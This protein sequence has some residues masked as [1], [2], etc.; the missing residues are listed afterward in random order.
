MNNNA[1]KSLLFYLLGALFMVLAFINITLRPN[2]VL[3]IISF[4]ACGACFIAGAGASKQA[5]QDLKKQLQDQ[6]EAE[7]QE[8]DRIAREKRQEADRIARAEKRKAQEDQVAQL[9]AALPRAE[10]STDGEKGTVKDQAEIAD[11]KY[12]NITV[13]TP[14]YSLED[15]V[16]VDLET[17]GTKKRDAIVS[18]AALV[19][20]AGEPVRAFYTLTDPGRAI[21]PEASAVNGIYD[22]DVKGAPTI[23]QIMPSLQSFI[24]ELPIV[25]HNLPFDLGYLYR[26]GV[27]LGKNK[28]FDT[29]RLARRVLDLEHYT[30]SDCCRDYGI[31]VVN[32]H[33]SLFDCY[34]TGQLFKKLADDLIN[35]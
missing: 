30:L 8:A 4:V 12:N 35:K 28:R 27:D 31:P 6:D 1:G 22:D 23:W 2:M 25:G 26:Y 16:V 9:L 15:F 18:V 10:I 13:K 17:T 20:E 5:E 24:G 14:A 7:K 3:F 32:A 29:L 21:P 34:M 33:Q 19:F 11:L